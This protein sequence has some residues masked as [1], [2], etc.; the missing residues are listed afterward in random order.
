MMELL[1]DLY[2][3]TDVQENVLKKFIPIAEYCIAHDV[4]ESMCYRQEFAEIDI[5]I[6]TLVVKV[7][8]DSIRYKFIPSENLENM[9]IEMTKTRKSPILSKLENNLQTKIEKAYKELL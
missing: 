7:D 3:L 2:I 9:M 4:Y 8:D 1:Q 5:G 6:G